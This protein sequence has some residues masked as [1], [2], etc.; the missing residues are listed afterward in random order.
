MCE[1]CVGAR[2]TDIYSWSPGYI[3]V[4][5]RATA[6]PTPNYKGYENRCL[7]P[8]RATFTA[9]L[10][11]FTL[12]AQSPKYLRYHLRLSAPVISTSLGSPTC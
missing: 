12:R 8:Y 5:V 1:P 3:L 4:L 7:F 9:N 6:F 10:D 2:S 11:L